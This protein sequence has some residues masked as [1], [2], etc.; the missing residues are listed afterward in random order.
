[1]KKLLYLILVVLL[2]TTAACAR[3][4]TTN[5]NNENGKSMEKEEKT[6]VVHLTKADFLSKVYNYEQNPN[7]WKYEGDVP[8]IVDFYATWCGPCKMLA[9]VLEKLGKEYEGRIV[10]YKVDV[11][12]ENE[13]ASA[14]GIR[15]VPTL[16][17]IPMEGRPQMVQ[18]A[19]PKPELK[20]VID[21]V[22]LKN[23]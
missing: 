9:P 12:A 15:S 13:L 5:D 20:K 22:L 17:L 4:A 21:D 8:A 1:M 10:I 7:E 6:Q 3:A 19:M 14:F 18:G 23:K 2:M 16:L 11:D